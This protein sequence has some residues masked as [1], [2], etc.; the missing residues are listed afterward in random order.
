MTKRTNQTKTTVYRRHAGGCPIKEQP[1]NTANC[2]CPLWI[3]GKIR[4][5]FI[6]E[7]LDTRTLATA[8]RRQSDLENGRDDDPGPGGGP[9]LV[10]KA[11]AK[12]DITLEYAASEFLRTTKDLAGNTQK[13]YARCLRWFTKWAGSHNLEFLRDI[14]SA[15]IRRYF[16]D[17]PGWGRGTQVV[18]LVQLGTFF[19][20]CKRTPRRWIAYAPTEERSLRP[21]GKKAKAQGN[22]VRVPFS[23]AQ[24]TAIL[25]AVEQMP[26]DVRDRARGLIY[27]LLYSGMRISDATF[28]ERAC[29]LPNNF[30]EYTVIK[31]GK[32]IDLPPELQKPAIDAL[33]KLPASRVYFF[34]EDAD[35]DYAAAR[36]ALRHGDGEF[37]LL[38]PRY[39]PRVNAM[40][41][42]VRRV[43][44]L[45]GV[46]GTCHSF[47]DT[48]AVSLLTQGV[49]VYSVSKALGHS[50][51]RVTD[52]HYLKLVPGYR[53]RMSQCT[54][55]LNYQ[56]PQAG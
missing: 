16:E 21:R 8:I 22:D 42:L 38:M 35:D 36:H 19:S 39:E 10:G 55:A 46:T 28:A 29:L 6:R 24:V 7:A 30:M 15:H 11:G 53:E 54:R 2:E 14:E 47:R 44:K 27:L 4:G 45:A 20:F 41:G 33:A 31:T 43:L 56:F 18:R 3:H 48:F 37:S 49:D 51:V 50:D 9:H 40:S 12:A 34:H 26:E 52:K 1:L 25:A 23:P 32:T 17:N 5:K 13:L